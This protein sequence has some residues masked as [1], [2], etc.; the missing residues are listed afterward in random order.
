MTQTGAPT[1]QEL[2]ELPHDVRLA[3]APLHKRS[4]GIAVGLASG[5]CVA[6]ATVGA[7][8]R[9]QVAGMVG[10]LSQYFPGYTLSWGGVAVGF[11]WGVFT[12]F[13]MAWFTAY[14]RNFFIAAWIWLV[15]T[16]AELQA[17]RDFLDHI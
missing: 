7:L 17:T 6:A 5:L 4:F 10:L 8:L 3:F 2:Q 16:K 15:R 9:P 12:G 11:A 1:A 13:V 14:C